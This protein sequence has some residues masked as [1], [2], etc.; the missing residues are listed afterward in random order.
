M[1]VLK[2]E[3]KQMPASTTP[4]RA[5][6]PLIPIAM[7]KCV[8]LR[9]SVAKA[10]SPLTKACLQ[11]SPVGL[12]NPFGREILETGAKMKATAWLRESRW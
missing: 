2:N 5:L 9:K 12:A 11:A 8:V 3:L 10:N 7:G 4:H 1:S 6:L